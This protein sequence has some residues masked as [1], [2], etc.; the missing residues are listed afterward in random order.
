ME[1]NIEAIVNDLQNVD[2]EHILYEAITNSIQANANNI[3]IKI[4]QTSILE[5]DKTPYI[6]KIE[7]ID[8]GDGFTENNTNSFKQYRTTFKKSFGAKG[9]GR[10][11]YLKL[12][13][14]ISI[15]S[16]DKHIDFTVLNDVQISNI[17]NQVSTK[18]IFN[19]PK[20]NLFINLD[21][22]EQDI[23]EHFLPHFSLF[24]KDEMVMINI[25]E[26]DIK[27]FTIDSSKIPTF[28]TD[29][30][31]VKN[32]KFVIKYIINNDKIR[33]NDGFYCANNRVVIKNS[34]LDSKIKLKAFK[35]VNIL[36]LLSSVY[37]DNN[38]NDER[39]EF[40]IYPN[41]TNQENLF[42][43]LSWIDIQDTLTQK[44]KEIFIKNDI[45]IDKKAKT[46]L[47]EA[48]E[49]APYLSYY[50]QNNDYGYKSDVL[51]S[52]AKKQLEE[53]KKYL[54][55]N[56]DKYDDDDYRVKLSIV[57]QSELAEYI[58]D[59][60]KIIER[61]KQLTS[62]E[63]LEKEIH[64]LFMKQKTKDESQNYK[65][66]NLWL[67]DD[68]FM[69]YDKVFSDKQ[70]KEIF[71]E[72]S[73]SLERPDILSIVSNT[74]KQ[75]DITDI[76]IIELKKPDDKITPARAEEQL[77][78]Y[79]SYVNASR[80]ENKIRVWTYAF[81]KFNEEI[82]N[83]LKRKSYNKIPTHS[84]YPI[85]YKYW[86]EPNTIINFLDYSALAFDAETRN[87]TFMNILSGKSI[88]EE[89]KDGL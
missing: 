16:L 33:K 13:D 64:N 47:Y 66:N 52:N 68:R 56:S 57:T 43:N 75:E 79:A 62:E 35:D 12:F 74:H 82:E 61:L 51:V 8:N 48:V 19:K 67:F 88:D 2:I 3:D 65:S 85:Y 69:S 55:H 54:R 21:T 84:Q 30:F 17:E 15:D 22:I 87:S 80:E 83:K 6:N 23:K 63:A 36:F 81:L 77:I 31:H 10:F 89:N 27:K 37:L 71:P 46:Y 39:N 4:Y 34:E 59:R 29:E 45:D 38:V 44:L 40:L 26:N 72:L 1:A 9:V 20:T 76:V 11:L 50:L 78:D 41:R 86:E 58:F 73:E 28:S 49:K 5:E 70:V 18:V 42:G 14:K 7:V 60:Q 24:K 32:H 53:D 25:Y